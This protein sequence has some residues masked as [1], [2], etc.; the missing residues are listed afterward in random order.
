M[1]K[2]TNMKQIGCLLLATALLVGVGGCA[3]QHPGKGAGESWEI[4]IDGVQ[5]IV[6][7][8]IWT[9]DRKEHVVLSFVYA[10]RPFVPITMTSSQRIEKSFLPM[11]P[12]GKQI[13]PK[14][15]TFYFIQDGEVVFEKG[16]QE[17]GI[18]ASR[19]DADSEAVFDYLRPILEKLIRENVPPQEADENITPAQ[20][21]P[22]E[23]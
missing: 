6:G 15:D 17:L 23:E 5:Y 3:R 20:D 2:L 4:K 7:R 19:L 13:A 12:N 10:Y 1:I 11:R 22:N 14:T 16:Y 9:D 18:D 8:T 21:A